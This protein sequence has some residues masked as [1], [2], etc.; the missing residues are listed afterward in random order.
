MVC[1]ATA[2][3]A[4]FSS[5]QPLFSPLSISIDVDVLFWISG[6]NAIERQTVVTANFSITAVCLCMAVSMSLLDGR[7]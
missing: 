7:R 3:A 4:Y 2:V 5:K 1:K 6:C